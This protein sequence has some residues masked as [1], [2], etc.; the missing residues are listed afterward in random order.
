[1]PRSLRSLRKKFAGALAVAAL[2]G[3]ALTLAAGG[4]SAATIPPPRPF[5]TPACNSPALTACVKIVNQSV[6][7]NSWRINV[8]QPNGHSWNRCLTGSRPGK[9]SY[10]TSV[11]FSNSDRVSLTAYRGGNCEGG[12]R[13]D[14]WWG[15]W[16]STQ[17]QYHMIVVNRH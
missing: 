17:D 7:A 3:G 15:N 6:D 2:A 14:N 8:T 1:M 4:A 11:W 5:P 16:S 12:T 9:T 13:N 10:Y